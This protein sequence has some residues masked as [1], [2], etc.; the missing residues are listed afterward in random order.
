LAV[1]FLVKAGSWPL[2]FWLLGAYA[3]AGAPVAAAF[4]L[5]T[6]VGI[7]ALLR[8]GTLIAAGDPSATFI[9]PALFYGGMATLV[10]GAIGLLA[11]QHLGRLVGFSVI[12]SSGTLLA[13]IGFS[14]EALTAPALFYLLTSV[15]AT[16]AFFMLTGMTERTRTQ[17]A[18][19][20]D[21][22]PLPAISY[23]AFGVRESPDPHSPD[24][25][26][27]IAIPA[28]MAF[29]GLSFV[30]CVLLL[31]GLPPLSGFIA[32]FALLS[33]ILNAGFES[34]PNATWSYM[35]MVI[36][37]GFAALIALTRVGMRLFWTNVTR[38]TPRLRVIEAAPV[39]FLLLLTVGLTIAANPV[40]TY[41]DS[42][43]RSLHDPQTYI[44][45]V[46]SSR[47]SLA[48]LEAGAP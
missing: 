29:L 10:V 1:A 40:M 13:A 5:M 28:V 31:A 35:A 7:Y 4:S 17:F 30:C 24:D 15:L 41:L 18:P 27:G 47:D 37:A 25:E 6:K 21:A 38:T 34:T 43:A 42:T 39:A 44:R 16:G 33:A 48:Q 14:S 11:A 3:A 23:E 36:I 9:G 22:A 26:V 32:K 20:A 2:N 12:V 46:L 45:V 8:I 19:T